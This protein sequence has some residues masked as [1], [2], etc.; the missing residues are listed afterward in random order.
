MRIKSVD[1]AGAIG[2]VGQ[3]QPELT[4]GMPQVAFSGRSNVGKSSLINRLL[5]RTR[6]AI[7]RVSAQPGKT[8][9]INFYSVRAEPADFILVDL[10][11]YGYAKVPRELRD[12]WQPLIHGFLSRSLELAGVVQLID[13]RTGPTVDD[14]KSV[15]YLAELGVPTLFAFTKADK[16]GK[17]EGEK[18]FAKAVKKLGI[19]PQQAIAFSAPKGTGREELLETLESLLFPHAQG[20]G[21]DGDVEANGDDGEAA[22]GESAADAEPPSPGA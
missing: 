8:Q 19:D 20:E 13:M 21:E 11:G 10:P 14:L 2:Q 12:R 16:L 22:A 18:A 9:E 15:E 5:G 17:M 6:T 3:A 4:R 7:A 1:F